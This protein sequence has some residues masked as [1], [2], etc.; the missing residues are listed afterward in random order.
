VTGLNRRLRRLVAEGDFLGLI[1]LLETGV[2][3]ERRAAARALGDLGD[4]R[5]TQPLGEALFTAYGEDE[6][7]PV[8]VVAALRELDAPG[9]ADQL[10]RLLDDRRDDDFYFMAQREAL[11]DLVDRGELESV[12]RVAGDVT[13]SSVLRKEAEGLLRRHEGARRP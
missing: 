8:L 10:K 6:D 1:H 7:L 11:F 9:V 13:R 3:R 12:E 4:P 2:R 5:A